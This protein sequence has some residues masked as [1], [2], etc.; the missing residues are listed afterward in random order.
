MEGRP[1]CGLPSQRRCQETQGPATAV[2]LSMQHPQGGRAL[3][4]PWL[5][6]QSV[7]VLSCIQKVAG[8]IPSWGAYVRQL[9][10]A[11]LSKINKYILR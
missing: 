11:S 5:G 8:L 10:D 4:Q 3:A 2:V 7:G 1:L 6:A 9:I